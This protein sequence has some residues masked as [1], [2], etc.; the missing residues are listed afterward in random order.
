MS[1]L[2]RTGALVA[3]V[4]LAGAG[5]AVTAAPAQAAGTDPRPVSVGAAWLTDHLVN[6]VIRDSYLDTFTDPNNP[7]PVDF[8]DLGLTMDTAMSLVAVGGHASTVATIKSAM[9]ARITETY[10]SFGTTYTGSAAKAAVYDR[11]VGGDPTDVGAGHTDLV[12]VV[13]DN[14]ATT[15]PIVGKIQNVN[16][17]PGGDTNTFGQAF[18]VRALAEAGSDQADDAEAFLLKQQCTD[19]FF[20]LNPTKDTTATNQTCQGAV[21]TDA[22]APDTDAT[23]I[24]LIQLEALATKSGA[25]T[26][27]IAAGRAW[28]LD[29]QHA[30]GSFGGGPSTSDPNANS[31]G[32]AGIA[33][34]GTGDAAAARA[35]AIWVRSLQADEVGK[36][37]SQLS[38][39]TGGIGYDAATVADGRTDGITVSSKDRWLR[40]TAPVLPVLKYAPSAT[41]A[42]DI[43]GPAGYVQ[44]GSVASY[45]ITGVVPGD[46]LCVAAFGRHKFAVGRADGTARVS[47]TVPSSTGARTVLVSDRGGNSSGVRTDVL[48]AKTLP[49][50]VSPSLAKRGSTVSVTVSGLAPGER[51]RVLWRGVV[52][53][54]GFAG[55]DG[56]YRTR[57]TV[58]TTLGYGSVT[59]YGE[60]STRKGS[61]AVTVVR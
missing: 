42:L 19:G 51:V 43:T 40:T 38:D 57:F 3:S 50:A 55:T 33:L 12:K 49:V 14:T 56:A 6:G 15:A 5:L 28:L 27:A 60:F 13:E 48:G 54:R 52:R 18:A 7:T 46:K 23:S 25:V 26:A 2:R 16:D 45:R 30:D 4:A 59:A 58:G 1:F 36:C 17:F 41:P 31:T 8:D 44:G 10:D 61:H 9:D 29:A 37:T 20:R 24:A 35:A 32:L 47:L 11:L 22:S 39:E 53:H 21:G 34:A